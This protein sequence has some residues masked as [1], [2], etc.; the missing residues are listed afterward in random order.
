M[1][2]TSENGKKPNLGPDF[3]PFGRN[4]GPQFFF[5]FLSFTST[6]SKTLCHAI[7]QW[8]LKEK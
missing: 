6:S 4:L 3:G 2:L 1:N 7:I 5:F 8:N